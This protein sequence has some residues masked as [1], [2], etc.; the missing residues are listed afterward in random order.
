MKKNNSKY[1]V[2]LFEKTKNLG[3]DIQTYAAYKLLPKVD[4]VIERES[5]N[6]F[7]PKSGEM[8][9]TIVSGWY[10]HNIYSFPPSPFIDPLIIS[11]H[12]TN[13][14]KEEMPE[15]MSDYLI[16][17]LKQHEPIGLRDSLLK[18]KIEG[19]GVKTYFSGCL[20]LTLK[21]FENIKKTKKICFVDVDEEVIEAA[22]KDGEDYLVLTH[23]IDA[24][25]N[26]KLSFEDRM[27]Q[28]EERLKIYQSAKCV[29]SSR[30]HVVLPCLA[31]GV[32]VKLIYDD[33]NIDVVNRLSDFLPYLNYESKE[34]FI[35]KP[36]Y[37]FT[38]S[39]KYLE[40]TKALE[41]K[42]SEFIKT[43]S[44]DSK[45]N[46][47]LYQK[48]FIEPKKYYDGI[49]KSE[50]DNKSIYIKEL[51]DR[52]KDLEHDLNKSEMIRDVL[53]IENDMLLAKSREYI[54]IINSKLYKLL[55]IFRKIVHKF[56]SLFRRG[57]N[58]LRRIK[59]KIFGRRK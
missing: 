8:V 53:S 20:T 3:D 52:I 15:Y 45:E 11:T 9:K 18:E 28:V 35:N 22:K 54:P 30:L 7:V 6:E 24:K 56:K 36:N 55:V 46:V 21:P 50:D 44:S 51:E 47:E 59:N 32:P 43:E 31:L 14:L 25:V 57:I 29:I 39:K 48:Y 41:D 23:N 13:H 34:E 58:L 1:G 4:Y 40:L 16:N 17:Y 37:K 2:I 5:I 42:V 10:L 27:K 38:N 19:L 33:S 26:S 12:F 49:R